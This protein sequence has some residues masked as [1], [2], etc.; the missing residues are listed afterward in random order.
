M[1]LI[2][3][4]LLQEYFYF[5]VFGM[6]FTHAFYFLIYVR[7]IENNRQRQLAFNR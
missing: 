4:N 3:M 1:I 5:L 6:R 2:E 7:L